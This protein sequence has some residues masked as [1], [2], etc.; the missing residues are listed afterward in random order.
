M[1]QNSA[2][3]PMP[4]LQNA[5]PAMQ[6]SPALGGMTNAAPAVP[7]GGTT[8]ADMNALVIEAAK[9]AVQPLQNFQPPVRA[10][11]LS[12][13][14]QGSVS[15]EDDGSRRARLEMHSRLRQIKDQSTDMHMYLQEQTM[16]FH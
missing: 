11:A 5:T 16:L 14:G 10:Q 13:S 2:D 4:M 1:L 8:P 3:L 7:L 9:A 12:E 15:M 6:T